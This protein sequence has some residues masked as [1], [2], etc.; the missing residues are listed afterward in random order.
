M[1]RPIAAALAPWLGLCESYYLFR[2]A[3]AIVSKTLRVRDPKND[4][5]MIMG[6]IAMNSMRGFVIAA[7]AGFAT[8]M[9]ATSAAQQ[10]KGKAV[11]TARTS[12][13]DLEER[14]RSVLD[15]E[16]K[17]KLDSEAEKLRNELQRMVRAALPFCHSIG[18]CLKD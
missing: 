1:A 17:T 14:I 12:Q 16:L 7:L 11:E 15:Q 13:S 10:T 9:V 2:V 3:P 4:A 5:F 18:S 8:I 6:G